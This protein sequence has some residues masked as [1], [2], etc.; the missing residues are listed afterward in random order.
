VG[1]CFTF[2]GGERHCGATEWIIA[3]INADTITI[4][5]HRCP[6]SHLFVGCSVLSVRGTH[7]V[8]LVA[9]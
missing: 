9:A 3:A 7:L 4:A 2:A 5:L 8:K 1:D 6:R